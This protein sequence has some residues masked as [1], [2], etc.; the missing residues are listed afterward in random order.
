MA[1]SK[2]SGGAWEGCAGLYGRKLL[3]KTCNGA[4]QVCNVA[5]SVLKHLAYDGPADIDVTVN[6]RV[7]GNLSGCLLP[8]P[9]GNQFMGSL[10]IRLWHHSYQVTI[11]FKSA[12]P[13]RKALAGE[14]SSAYPSEMPRRISLSS[15][16]LSIWEISSW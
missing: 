4:L 12:R 3:T 6:Q 14:F 2:N 1:G 5:E 7:S 10:E 15:E 8:F 13:V 9:D 16:I 11:S